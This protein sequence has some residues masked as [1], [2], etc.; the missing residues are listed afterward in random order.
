ME[1]VSATGEPMRLTPDQRERIVR[2]VRGQFGADSAVWLYGSRT[3]S[4]GRGGDVDLLIRTSRAIDATEQARLH[5]RLE[6]ELSL[7]VDVSFI[8]PQR[9]MNRFQRLVAAEALPV[10]SP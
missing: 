1:R 10:E 7:P 9:G 3:K 8:D 2:T 5:G 4:D 6:H